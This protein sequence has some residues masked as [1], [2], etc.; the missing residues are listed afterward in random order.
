MIAVDDRSVDALLNGDGRCLK[1]ARILFLL[2][3]E[4]SPTAP[5]AERWAVLP[6]WRP[7]SLAHHQELPK[8]ERQRDRSLIS[9]GDGGARCGVARC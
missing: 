5:G 8:K 1:H 6:S 3:V 7:P 4:L 2:A 9:G